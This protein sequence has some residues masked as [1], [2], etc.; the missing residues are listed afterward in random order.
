MKI[1]IWIGFFLLFGYVNVLAQGPP[2]IN[3]KAIMLGSGSF[4]VRSLTEIRT[5][6]RGRFVYIPFNATYLPTSNTLV[7]VNIP[8][9]NYN[10]DDG[11]NGGGIADIQVQGK[12]QFIQKDGTGKTFRVLAKTTQT[13]PTGESLDLINISTGYYQGYYG[14]VGAYET[15]KYGITTEFGYNWI[16]EGTLDEFKFNLGFGLPLLKPQYPNKQLNLFFEYANSWVNQRGWYQLLY[17]QGIQYALK[18][19][20]FDVA[21]QIPIVNDVDAGRA[22]RYGLF[23]GGRYSF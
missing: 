6:E 20:T 3:D 7:G 16:P 8:F 18:T 5:T 19:V 10:F 2:I 4:T 22:L 13:V 1:F 11:R 12:Y 21:V 23:F 17:A 14:F 15:L 9:V